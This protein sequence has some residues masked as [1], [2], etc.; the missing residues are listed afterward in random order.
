MDEDR[1]K[2]GVD[3]YG[4]KMQKVFGRLEPGDTFGQLAFEEVEQKRFAS[5]WVTKKAVL[6]IIRREDFKEFND[7]IAYRNV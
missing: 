2:I 3:R 1:L 7:I 5:A 4:K 6:L